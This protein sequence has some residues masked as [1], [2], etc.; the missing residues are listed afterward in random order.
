MEDMKKI[1]NE[2]IIETTEEVINEGS[3][4]GL[5]ALGIGLVLVAGGYGVYKLVRKLKNKYSNREK[6]NEVDD[7]ESDCD[8]CDVENEVE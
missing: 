2:E 8:N 5:K 6:L 1:A 4:G 3:V 7:N